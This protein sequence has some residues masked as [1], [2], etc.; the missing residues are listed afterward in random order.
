MTKNLRYILTLVA[1]LMVTTP[2]WAATATLSAKSASVTADGI[3]FS[4]GGSYNISNRLVSYSYTDSG[5]EFTLSWTVPTGYTISVSKISI[6]AKNSKL[7]GTTG[8][9]QYKTSKNGTYTQFC[10]A[11]SWNTY[12]LNSSSYFPLGNGGSI[13][14]KAVDRE[15]QWQDIVFEYTKT[16]NKYNIAF[17]ANG[18]TGTTQ[19]ISNI[20]YDT[21]VKLTPNGFTRNKFT[22]TY[23]ANGG[24]CATAQ[25]IRNYT[26]AG[27]AETSTGNVKYSDQQVVRNLS[28]TNGATVTLYAKWNEPNATITL[29]IATKEGAVLE[30]WY[31]GETKIG[32]AG[33]TYTPTSSVTL[34]AKWI[35]KYTPEITG[36][37]ATMLVGNTLPNA[38]TFKNTFNPTA[39]ITTKSISDIRNGNEVITYDAI[40]N[41]IIAH[42]AGIAEIYFYQAATTTIEEGYSAT[43]TITVN[44]RTTDFEI[45]FA[46]EYFV[47]DEINKNTFF[48]NS[49][50][51]EVAIQVSDKTADNRA[52]FTY[53]NS[54]LKANGATLNA[55][56]E[57]TTITVTQPET[58]KWT[59]KSLTKDVIVKKY[60]TD[61]TWLLKDRY[62]V[63]D[64]ITSIFSKTNNSLPT[65][66]TSSDPNIV[67]VEGNQLVALNAGKATITISQATDRKWVAFTQT[68]EITVLKH[69]IVATINPNTAYWNELVNNP[70]SASSTHA[71][72]N[73]TTSITDFSVT[74]QDNEHIATL[75]NANYNIQT[76]YTNGQVNFLITRDEDYKYNALSQTLTLTVKTNTESCDIFSDPTE[77]N[78]STGIT[79]FTGKAGNAYEI[80]ENVR[81]YADS[82]YIT[83]KRTGENYFYLQYST[84]GG[85]QWTD[86]PEG[87]LK[88]STNYQTFGVKIPDN[89]IV[90]HIRPFAKTGATLSKYYKDFRVTRKKDLTPSE[91][92]VVLP[93]TSIGT[94]EQKTFTLNWSTCADEILLTNSN[95]RFTLD[96]YTISP[97][98]NQGSTTI[99]VTCD[100]TVVGTL[101]DTIVIYDQ[102]QRIFVPVECVVNDKFIA[103]IKGTTSYSKMVNDTLVADFRFDTC[104]TSLPSAD[105]NAPLYYTIDHDLTGNDVQK[106]GFENQVITYDPE[107]NT[108]IAHNAGTAVLTFIQQPTNSHYTD[109]LRCTITVSKYDVER[110]WNDP[111]YFNDTIYNYFTTSNTASDIV[112]ESQT[113]T[114][115]AKLTNEFNPTS[116]NSL[117][118]ITFN[119]EAST[120][121]TVSQAETYYWNGYSKPHTITPIDPNNHVTFTINS[122]ERRDVFDINWE[123]PIYDWSDGI[124]L[125]D[126]SDGFNYD[127]K[128]V[129][130]HFTGIPNKLGFSTSIKNAT[131]VFDVSGVYWYVKESTNGTNWSDEIWNQ[132]DTKNI[133][134]TGDSIQLDPDTRYLR[135][136]YSGNFGGVF[137]NITVTELNQFE[138]R[139]DVLDFGLQYVDNPPAIKT[140]DFHYANA[141]Y[142]VYLESTD[143]HFTLSTTYIDT[144]GGEKYGIVKDIQVTYTPS[145]VHNAHDTEAKILIWDEIGNRDT[146]FLTA[147]T[148]K[149]T[150]TLYWT[151]A[152]SATEP[153]VLLDQTVTNAAASTNGYSTVKYRSSNENKIR[154]INGGTAF[155]GID[156]GRVVITAYQEPDRAYNAPEEIFKT[157][158]VTDKIAQYIVW[159]DNLTNL[160]IGDA[161]VTLT[162]Q[163]WVMTDAAT[164]TWEYSPEQTAKLQYHSP[165]DAVV[166]VASNSNILNINGV[167]ELM[168][169]AFILADST[170]EYAH[171][172]VPVRVRDHSSTC[173]DEGLIIP[174]KQNGNLLNLADK[175]EY[176]PYLRKEEHVVEIDTTQGVPGE[177][178]FGY[179]GREAWW[180]LS[181]RIRVYES[182]DGGNSYRQ[183]LSD[184]DAVTPLNQEL[185]YSPRI[186]LSRN[187]THIK[188]QRFESVN[189]GY[190]ILQYITILPAKYIEAED[191]YWGNIYL[192]NTPD[193]TITF[194]YSSV[195]GDMEF[196]TSHTN[197]R[198]SPSTISKECGDWGS[199]QLTITLVAAINVIGDF[200]EQVYI[201]DK[202]GNISDTINVYATIIKNNPTITWET[203]LDTIRSSAEWETQKTAFASSGDQVHYELTEGDQMDEYAYL[204]DS[205]KMILL[206]GGIITARAYTVETNISNEV[207]KYRRF[208]ILVDPLFEDTDNDHNWLNDNNWNIGRTPWLTDSATI[209]ADKSVVLSSHITIH[210]LEFQSNSNIHILD[211]AGLTVGA[212]GITGAATDGSSLIIDNLKTGAG[213]L[214]ISP[215]YT[216]AMPKVTIRY[217]TRSTL[218]TGANKDATWQYI[219][220]PGANC[221]FTVDY[222]TWFY[223]WSEPQNWLQQSGTLTLSPFAG[224]AITQYGQP[225]YE[226]IAEPINKDQTI[227]LTKTPEN[228]GGMDGDNLFANSFMA[229]IDIK[230]FTA[231]DFTGDVNKTFYIFN[232]GSWNQWN[233]HNEKD[234]TLGNNG[235]TTPGQYCAIP[236]LSAKYLDSDITTL[237]PM[238]GI[239]V[240]ANENGAT[241][242]LNYNK[243]VFNAGNY[244]DASTNM[245]EPMRA[246]QRD[247]QEQMQR[248]DFLRMRLQVNSANSGA[249]R[250][251]IIQEHTTTRDYDNGYDA[252]NQF[253]EGIANIYTTEAFGKMEVT[254][255]NNID[256]MYIGFQAGNDE[257]YTL[258]YRSLIGES[259]YLK[260]LSNDS[261]FLLTEGGQ[262]HFTAQP[263]STNDLRFQLLLHIDNEEDSTPDNEGV[264]TDIDNVTG[265][266]IWHS[267]DH[268]YISNAPANS[269]LALYTINGQLILSTNIPHTTHTVD[270]NYL[271]QGVYLLQLGCQMY[272]FVRQ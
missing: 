23:D 269:T 112:I 8:K 9:G 61:F 248:N 48:T 53:N 262:Y 47:D 220:A 100:A 52:L 136:C 96:K 11:N 28:A 221:Q 209:Q 184:A 85:N 237:P 141:G 117:D 130:L 232:S 137:H 156:T 151:Q 210:G 241:I 107:S 34:T 190:H 41:E 224:Y 187:A 27:W 261:I 206:R 32:E 242:K 62:Y 43:Y 59:G 128:Y 90:T 165:N 155:E 88:L 256:S 178:I 58:Y 105:I 150:P 160:R 124:Q 6:N 185:Q 95:P 272:K 19:G 191:V 82:V 231:D 265:A 193:T 80:P 263:L 244:T 2:A 123:T 4:L 148:V 111:V 227:V 177:L 182:T 145:E 139:P 246:P 180:Q 89:I 189:M 109:T 200:H 36:S 168:L 67:K 196:S 101:R 259:L 50:N 216:S 120:T 119:K 30:G 81:V 161:P 270:L 49:T 217:Q 140:F 258:S 143:P 138:A 12:T 3:T 158:I 249:D 64:V 257:Q 91:S 74:Q 213:F 60:P 38:F 225:T 104:Q 266:H 129:E 126:W 127:D 162:A 201:Y 203:T 31:L 144:I 103:N 171:A 239:Y 135:L 121:V 226:L 212:Q 254:C 142:K 40:E 13:T 39:V 166:S 174:V 214:R 29:P 167:G 199:E 228:L 238:Q 18:G 164:N 235:S 183:I 268:V 173:T 1:I 71:V 125:G 207:S 163:V 243:H 24:T 245:N 188:F 92:P 152:W 223:Q 255:A 97:T 153:I 75:N 252:P 33:D 218:D 5:D 118:L 233:G 131:D 14:L 21:D 204:N 247:A 35:E 26:F 87:E 69:D 159:E 122:Q 63:D 219:G 146:V 83:A 102:T 176:D 186:P 154:I 55:N 70:F 113:D 76:Y 37:N 222:I 215:E 99:T 45:N 22:I 250:M 264:T 78:F 115:V 197:L 94:P 16:A 172:Q 192:G 72:T 46:N 15:L 98:N 7:W 198:V 205:G 236:A 114:D 169:E 106:P 25:E 134:I 230:N 267:N 54:I 157:F 175:L 253:A 251:Y 84:N 240:I 57:T 149:S 68:K 260:D 66:I 93:V 133:T 147:S 79:D 234:S 51:G 77:R 56:S 108:I 181:G 17:D 20:S 132:E 44:K 42:N 170:Y 208:F 202:V 116:N 110:I 211:S 271:P 179:Y 73:Q 194:D 229:P 195:R 86:F 10:N 65:T